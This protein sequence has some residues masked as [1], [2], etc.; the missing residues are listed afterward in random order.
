MQITKDTLISE[1]LKIKPD[2]AP[3][4]M[5]YGM[6]C[7]GCPSAQMESLE[8]AA[9]VHGIDLEKLLEELNK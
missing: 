2:A 9:M 8:Q 5:R 4:L 7:L 6:G 3:I 1:I